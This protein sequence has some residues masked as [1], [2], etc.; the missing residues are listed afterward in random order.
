MPYFTIELEDE[1]YA[2]GEKG[3]V[4]AIGSP[5]NKSAHYLVRL[6]Q[7]KRDVWFSKDEVVPAWYQE[8]TGA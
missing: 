6:S 7:S 1:V 3:K 4:I 5:S 8:K 2:G